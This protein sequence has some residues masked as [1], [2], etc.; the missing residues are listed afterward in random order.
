MI[1]LLLSLAGAALPAIKELIEGD[2]PI[3]TRLVDAAGGIASGLTGE[4]DLET[5]AAAIQ[6]DPALFARFQEALT[7]R[8]LGLA[9]EETR[10]LAEREASWRAM[11]GSEDA[12]VR[13]ARP[14]IIYAL[15]AIGLA[16]AATALLICWREPVLLPDTI[17]ALQW[18]VYALAG[19]G[20]LY[21]VKRSDDKAAAG[22]TEPPAGA[23]RRLGGALQTMI[24]E[25][26][27]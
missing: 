14:T 15:V 18:V 27:K 10:R 5:A 11:T 19:V 3:G 2:Q 26:R 7:R 8:A 13:R 25:A 23:L 24:G 12:Y 16:A 9:A 20:G 22:G 4:P 1:P 21:V 17:A 6:A